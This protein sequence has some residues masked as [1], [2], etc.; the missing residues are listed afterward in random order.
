MKIVKEEDRGALENK[1]IGMYRSYFPE[2][3]ANYTTGY[4]RY[5]VRSIIEEVLKSD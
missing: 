2:D 3:W 1:L 4:T 5:F